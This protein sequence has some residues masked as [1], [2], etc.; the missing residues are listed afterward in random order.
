MDGRFQMM[1]LLSDSGV[2]KRAGRRVRTPKT[3]IFNNM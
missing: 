2:K 1:R 3:A